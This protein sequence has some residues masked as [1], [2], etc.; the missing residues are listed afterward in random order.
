[1]LRSLA[2]VLRRALDPS[3]AV[4]LSLEA[5]HDEVGGDLS[6]LEQVVMNLAINARDAMP[7]GG[8]LTLRT[9][10]L[11]L[12]GDAE[13]PAGRFVAL[14]LA[15]SGVGIHPAVRDRM[16]EPYVSSKPHGGGLGLATVYGIVQAHHGVIEALDHPPRG[17]LIRVT[18]PVATG[19]RRTQTQAPAP[20][21]KIAPGSGTVLLVE[22]EQLVR[23][24]TF[25]ALRQ[26]GYQVIACADGDEAVE[27]FRDR[28]A[29][30][31]GVLLDVA[32]PKMSGRQTYIA[33]HEIDPQVR[34][35]LMAGNDGDEVDRILSLGAREFLPKPFELRALSQAL[36]RVLRT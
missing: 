6:Q 25:R 17:T 24:A 32:M 23:V 34:V 20:V 7:E 22:D 16:F 27:I 10:D 5:E 30:I 29:D 11:T 12:P 21:G 3:I 31:H 18:L 14:E 19:L 9:R 28:R 2:E 4:E 1:M 26:L 36:E 15:D 35:L 8:S 13:L 33:L